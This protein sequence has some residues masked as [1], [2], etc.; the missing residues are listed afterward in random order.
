MPRQLRCE[1]SPSIAAG[2]KGFHSPGNLFDALALAW[3]VRPFPVIPARNVMMKTYPILVCA[4]LGCAMLPACGRSDERPAM[5]MAS[6]A[7]VPAAPRIP[8]DVYPANAAEPAPLSPPTA[9]DPLSR[10]ALSD[11]AIAGK[12]T[13]SILTDP[14]LT[15]ADISVN[16]DRGVVNLAGNVKSQE[17]AAIASIHAQR[18]DGVMRVDNHLAV[19]PQ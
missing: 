9:P 16:T 10:E 15:G 2:K 3:L 6:P 13:A 12:I 4:L 5:A 14:S 8:S 17:Q 19:S 7:L 18:E 11:T 1:S